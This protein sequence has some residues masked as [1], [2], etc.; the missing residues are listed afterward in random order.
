MNSPKRL[1]RIAGVLYLLVGIFGGF[2]EG[3]VEP[4]MYVPGDAAAT[5]ANVVA[6]AGLVRL[7]VV[8][9]LVDQ[10]IFVFLAMTLYVLLKHVHKSAAAAMVVLVALAAGHRVLNAVFEFAGLRVAT[11][12][13]DCPPSASRGRTPSCCS[14]WTPSTTDC[15]SRRSSSACGWCRWAISPTNPDGSPRPWRLLLVVAGGC[16]LVDLLAAFLVPDVSSDDP[17][18]HRH[19]VHHRG[20]LDGRLPARDRRADRQDREAGRARPRRSLKS[21]DPA[22]ALPGRR[23]IAR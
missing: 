12:A 9:D 14:C 3:Y 21:L 13:V 2:A 6:N 17:H 18:L 7:G 1:A 5:A 22:A 16:Y 10:T 20:D 23:R 15:S 8:A 4:T 19:P 11:G